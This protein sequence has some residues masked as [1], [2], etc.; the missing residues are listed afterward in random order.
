MVL[1]WTGLTGFLR[2]LT[3]LEQGVGK[4]IGILTMWATFTL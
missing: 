4:E 1:V 2:G 3:G